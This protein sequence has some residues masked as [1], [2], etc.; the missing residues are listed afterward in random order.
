MQKKLTV[1]ELKVVLEGFPDDFVIAFLPSNE[2]ADCERILE[3][4]K[5]LHSTDRKNET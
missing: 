2:P 1:G 5:K 4:A 3:Y